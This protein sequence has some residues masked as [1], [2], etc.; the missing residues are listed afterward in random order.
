[1]VGEEK[2]ENVSSETPNNPSK[3]STEKTDKIPAE[4][5]NKTSEISK[6]FI[7]EEC[8]K[9]FDTKRK[10]IGHMSSHSKKSET[11]DEDLPDDYLDEREILDRIIAEATP[12][13]KRKAIVRM[14][15]WR[16]I[17]KVIR[18]C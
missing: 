5:S 13:R 2:V 8:G 1:M 14:V 17:K 4:I 9:P 10:L 6:N 12:T 7:C 16:R 18:K 3:I 11:T 15:G